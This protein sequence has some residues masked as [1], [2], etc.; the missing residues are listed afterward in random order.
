[1]GSRSR[2]KNILSGCALSFASL[3]VSVGSIEF[4]CRLLEVDFSNGLYYNYPIFYRKPNVP[5]GE[6]FFRRSGPEAWTGR[7]LATGLRMEGSRENAFENEPV[8]TVDYSG[9][10]FRNPEELRDWDIVVVGDS[11]TELGALPYEQL[12]T[13]LM[14]RQLGLRVKNLGVCYTATLSQVHF[15]RSFGKAPSTR[16]ALLV[17]FEGND[18]GETRD[19]LA[20]LDVARTKGV[21]P[22]LPTTQTSFLA[23]LHG[24]W[25][26]LTVPGVEYANAYYVQ[27]TTETPVTIRY[28]PPSAGK[29]PDEDRAN[30]QTTLSAYAAACGE[31]GLEPWLAF[32]PCKHRVLRG[33][34]RFVPIEPGSVESNRGYAAKVRAWEGSDLPEYVGESA[35]QRGL[36][37]V[38]LTPALRDRTER[39][40]LTYNGVFDTHLN[41]LGSE[42]VAGALFR[43]MRDA[44]GAGADAKNP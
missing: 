22:E 5:S 37:F 20:R 15:L 4:A 21:Q 3:A 7:V 8:V 24:L 11:F 13:T 40:E 16:R 14:G 25:K 10:G 26:T 6:A 42:V 36:R 32:M 39:G 27:G 23:A 2:I 34:L 18:I 43:A 29:L 44:P 30:L 38:D 9:E 31:L 1:M 35:R 12:F 17:W 33:H 41:R 19:E 28:S